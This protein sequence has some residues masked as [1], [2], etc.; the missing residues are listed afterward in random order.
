MRSGPG[1]ESPPIVSYGRR[2]DE[3]AAADPDAV[4]IIGVDE[5]DATTDRLTRADLDIRTR[6]AAGVLRARGVGPSSRIVVE[7]PN[8]A[9]H[10]VA[11]IGAWRLGA[12]VLPISPRLPA[13]ERDGLVD[14]A[15]P[16][17]VVG[18][19]NHERP[20]DIT[21]DE[22]LAGPAPRDISDV[23]PQPGKAIGSGG[24]T[25]RSK[26]IVDPRPWGYDPAAVEDEALGFSPGLT[27]LVCGPL[28]HNSPF[29]WSTQGLLLGQTIVVM[30]RFNA[31]L[32]VNLIERYRVGWVF[33]APTM[34][35]R[36]LDL[37]DIGSRDL[38]SLRRVFH[39]AGPCAPELKRAWIDLVGPERLIESYGSTEDIGHTQIS[40]T[41]WLAHPGSVGRGVDT[42]IRIVDD[43][44]R[45]RPP[46]E[47]GEIYLR[48]VDRAEPRH[49][50]LGSPPAPTL[51]DGSSSVGDL[52]WLDD[53]GYLYLA[54][55]RVDMI[56]TGGVNVYPAEVEAALLEHPA[57]ADVAVVG[58]PDDEWGRRVHAV[59]QLRAAAGAVDP[60]VFDAHLRDRVASYK[61]PKT[62]DFVPRLP[63]D[64]SGKIRRRLLVE[65]RVT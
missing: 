15:S 42:E 6:T 58:L 51:A 11:C 57:V 60:S 4:A 12:L 24:S 49:V 16:A 41:E 47:V 13:R 54:D 9:D 38:S 56:V 62:Y 21:P 27:Q 61:R 44:G 18:V 30:A 63:R 5:R 7:L 64:E 20:P 37:P 3:L 29:V 28:Y 36:I 53:D 50:Y 34:M 55:R 25:G 48:R 33:L 35:R 8:S 17:L 32:A 65:E 14:L 23:V 31:A 46:G 19:P 39:T 59:V 26:I 45:P 43:A 52:G 10:L 40:G 2:I 1:A 22:L